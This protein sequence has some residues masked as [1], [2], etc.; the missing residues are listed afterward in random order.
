MYLNTYVCACIFM[1]SNL[2]IHICT[3][4]QKIYVYI[5]IYIYVYIFVYVFEYLYIDYMHM[6]IYIY[7]YKNI[8]LANLTPSTQMN[9]FQKMINRNPSSIYRIGL[10][11]STYLICQYVTIDL[12]NL[13]HPHDWMCSTKQQAFSLLLAA[14]VR[15]L[16][17]EMNL[18]MKMRLTCNGMNL[19]IT[20]SCGVESGPP[21]IGG[22][23]FVFFHK[24]N[25]IAWR[26]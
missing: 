23:N 10:S 1:W 18:H 4:V 17:N 11:N 26:G 2:F 6:H 21:P 16:I 3:C 9:L 25:S 15:W 20:M 19:F 22:D 24:E 12:A 14:D 13:T 7:I 5:N 8:E